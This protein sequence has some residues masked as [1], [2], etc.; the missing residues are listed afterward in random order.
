MNTVHAPVVIIGGGPAGLT[1]AYEL[2]KRSVEALVLEAL[3]EVGGLA[4][5][6]NHRGCLFDLGGHRFFTQVPLVEQLWNEVLGADMLTRERLSRIYSGGRFFRYPLEP[7]E[8][9]RNLG[10][11]ECVRCVASYVWSQMQPARPLVTLEDW[12]TRHFGLRLYQRFF[13]SYTEKVWGRPCRELSAEWAAQRVQ[14]LS[15]REVLRDAFKFRPR[16]R[17]GAKTLSRSFQYPRQ[18]PGMLWNRVREKAEAAGSRIV[19]NAKVDRIDWQPGRLEAVQASGVE[20]RGDHF[21]SSMPVRDL[22]RC[23]R[24]TPPILD[25]AADC[26]HYR[27]FLVVA[28]ILKCPSPFP[29]NWIYVH[30]P[31]VRVGRIQNY[32]NWSPEM[33]P[34]PSLTCLGFEYFCNEGDELWSSSDES[35][36]DRA[37]RELGRIGLCDPAMVIDAAALRVPMAYPVYDGSHEKGLARI[38]EFLKTVPNLQLVGRNGM[39][40]YNNQD[41]SMLTAMLAVRN[42][43]GANFDL[44]EVNADEVYHENGFSLT[45]ED[46]H[47]M[48]AAQPLVPR[49]VEDVA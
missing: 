14:G 19:L 49:Q 34:D 47:A 15:L 40:R 13:A 43:L 27:D 5:T 48:E 39:H 16:G 21:V 37:R 31:G 12:F 30:D 46:F 26:F 41:H 24:P 36:C 11:I 32:G 42:I 2:S 17:R 9:F 3:G 25:G 1:A 33:V 7:L 28:L 44:W 18:G 8:V 38:R 10:A 22:I 35:I 6:A 29:D 23:L 20:Y 45:K 4:R